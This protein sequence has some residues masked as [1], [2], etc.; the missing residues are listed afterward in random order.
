[1]RKIMNETNAIGVLDTKA[2]AAYLGVSRGSIYLLLND[3]TLN[4]PRP[5]QIG[6]R[7]SGFLKSE[8]DSWLSSRPRGLRAPC[9]QKAA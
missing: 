6:A 7:K 8:I 9:I 3:A 4:F 1:M 5:V 2:A